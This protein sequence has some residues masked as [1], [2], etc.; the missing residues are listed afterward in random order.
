[1]HSPLPAQEEA[2]GDL[3]RSDAF[4]EE[5]LLTILKNI[6]VCIPYPVAPDDEKDYQML[7]FITLQ[8]A[9]LDSRV[10]VPTAEGRIDILIMYENRVYVAELKIKGNAAGAQ[11]QIEDK[12]YD[13]L[14]HLEGKHVTRIAIVFD[15]EKKTVKDC[16]VV[17]PIQP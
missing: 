9:G 8:F 7:L 3:F 2:L 6:C 12:N 4:S 17:K 10:E 11:Q 15:V 1:M 13:A 5:K 16:S 14:Y